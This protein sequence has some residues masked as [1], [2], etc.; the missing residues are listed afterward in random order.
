MTATAPEL[1]SASLLRA[2]AALRI[3]A[4]MHFC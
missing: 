4:I 2:L 1:S 3:G